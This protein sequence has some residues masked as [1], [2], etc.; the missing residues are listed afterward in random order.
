MCYGKLR[1]REERAAEEE[2]RERLWDL[3][4]HEARDLTPTEPIAEAERELEREEVLTGAGRR[5]ND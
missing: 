3:F 4:D 2:R 1:R 5:T